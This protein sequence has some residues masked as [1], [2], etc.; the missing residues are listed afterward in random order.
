MLKKLV[1]SIL[2]FEKKYL[3]RKKSQVKYLLL[4]IIFL[5]GPNQT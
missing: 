3:T 4:S 1:Y 2:L 5:G